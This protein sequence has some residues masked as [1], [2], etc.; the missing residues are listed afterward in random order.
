[1]TVPLSPESMT[2]G[3]LV[4]LRHINP[5]FAAMAESMLVSTYSG[6]VDLLIRDINAWIKIVEE[7]PGIR[8]E[9]DEDRLTTELVTFLKARY[10][11]ASREQMVG[12]HCDIVVRNRLGFLWLGEAKVHSDYTHLHKGFRQLCDRYSTGTPSA[13]HGGLLIYMRVSKVS[14]VM[15]KWRTELKGVNLPSYIE[16][17]CHD[18]R[19]GL[20]FSSAHQHD[21]TGLTYTVRHMAVSLR[22]EPTDALPSST[23]RTPQ[24]PV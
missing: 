15:A 18:D 4:A 17:D 13:N 14:T 16:N 1:M 20:A 10:Y 24:K 5:D 7:E 23:R 6:F 22:F 12:G 11:D 3:Q 19:R 8:L 21:R 9:D 2:L